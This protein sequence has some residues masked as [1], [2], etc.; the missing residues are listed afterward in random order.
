MQ[1]QID[2]L[3]CVFT[4]CCC[5]CIVCTKNSK[6]KVICNDLKYDRDINEFNDIE[7]RTPN[8]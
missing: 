7:T 2:D 4:S 6:C 5:N 8:C 1:N 3:Q